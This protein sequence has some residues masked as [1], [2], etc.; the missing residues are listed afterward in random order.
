MKLRKFAAAL[1]G[2][3]LSVSLAAPALAAE[4]ADARLTRVTLA[5]KGTL[6]IGD[7]YTEFYGEPD[8]TPLGTRWSLSWTKEEEE[9][10][11]TATDEG[12]VI[13]LN[14]WETGAKVEPVSGAGYEGLRFPVMTMEEA[15]EYAGAFLD[16]VLSGNEKVT[17]T[18]NEQE[19]L[20][21]QSYSFQGNVEL[22]G[23]P[24]PMTVSARVRLSD[25][26]VTRF[27]RGDVSDY[28]GAPGEAKT[29]T[30]D[31]AARELLK[32]TLSLRLE[33]VLDWDGEE[34]TEK[35]AV[36]RYLPNST[37]EFYVDA[38]TG[39]LVNLTELREKL[40][41]DYE[42]GGGVSNKFMASAAMDAAVPEE[43][44]SLTETELEGVAKLEG[45]LDKDGL[46]KKIRA[47]TELGLDK[48]TL[49][50]AGYN[51]DR[52]TGDVTARVSYGKNTE[53]GI[54]R[55]FVTVDA[56]TGELLSMYGYN[57][58]RMVLMEE[59]SKEYKA[60]LTNAAAQAKGEAFLKKLWGE[61]F[62]KTERYNE[63]D[64]TAKAADAS[65]TFAQKV[66]GYFFP[67]NSISVR[68][69]GTDGSIMGFSKDFDEDVTFNGADGLISEQAAIE[70]WCDSFPVE[71]GY[72]EIPVALDM[73]EEFELL[74]NA[75]YSYYNALK[76]GYAL[77]DRESWYSGVDAKT[78]ELVKEEWTEEKS[79]SYDD[80]EGHWAREILEELARYNVGWMGGK[81]EP[82]KALTQ[83]DYLSLLSS[84]DGYRWDLSSEDSVEALYAYAYRQGILTEEERRE[85][86]A[87]TRAE[88]VR[89]F[90]NSQGYGPVARLTGIFRCDFA[91]ADSIPEADLGYAALA[92]GLKLID[93]DSRGN[94]AP[95]RPAARCEA[96]VMLWKYL[97]R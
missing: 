34:G 18:E 76:P 74:R 44:P 59:D 37:D 89:M 57:P 86:K 43:A 7:E 97:K 38:A 28:A 39:E 88:V 54:C 94:Y 64:E 1:T 21:A 82:D 70:A 13:S 73:S 9:L 5:V 53:E 79:M 65:F 36:L 60:L 19:S 62:A 17:F 49:G 80:L 72:M 30:T 20:S 32:D 50:A 63:A 41:R 42:T 35:K 52:E 66:N 24:S 26:A 3:A 96:A 84:A 33:Y 10:R 31:T 67:A 81:A 95:S 8:E 25:G 29:S 71:L 77:G 90:L 23:L 11:V 68:V 58:S 51:V 91:D 61:Q 15:R 16:K 40:R 48:Y 92:Q 6:G 47:W 93:G 22:N 56:K 55:R 87:L 14:R 45:V 46:D 27:W 12:K 2:L 69:D 4:A 78:G 75:G 83:L 85:D